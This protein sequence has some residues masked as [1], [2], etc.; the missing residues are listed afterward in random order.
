VW[1]IRKNKEVNEIILILL[2]FSRAENSDTNVLAAALNRAW[3]GDCKVQ[4]EGKII[5]R[6][7]LNLIQF[8]GIGREDVGSKM[9]N[10]LFI[11]FS[12]NF[13]C[14][15]LSECLFPELV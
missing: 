4:N 7:N 2:F 11:I 12:L 1:E 5:N 15:A 8:I 6:A 14:A 3:K 9:E 10:R 13:L